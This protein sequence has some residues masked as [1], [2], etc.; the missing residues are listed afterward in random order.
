MS[1]FY[2]S[3]IHFGHKNCISFDNRPW[4][5]IEQHDKDIIAN[6]NKAVGMTDT[7]YLLGDISWHDVTTTIDYFNQLNG[8]IVLIR[9]NH[10]VKLLKN[11]NLQNRF[12][13]I[14]DYKE[15]E[16]NGKTIILCHYPIPTFNKHYYGAYHFY[17]HVHNGF[18]WNM[19][20]KIK[21]EMIQLYDKPCNM[22]NVGCMM[23]YIKYTPRMF[24]EIAE[25]KPILY[26][27]L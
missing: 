23:D 27:N 6:W 17:G 21:D 9:G 20:E 26:E 25:R 15:I 24:E 5:D 19:I 10:D 12:S 13:E 22:F 3:D 2:I 18:E 1:N 7:V 14:T 16:D 4:T 8:N 11:R